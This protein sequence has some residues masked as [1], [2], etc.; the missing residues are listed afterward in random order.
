MAAFARLHIRMSVLQSSA[1]TQF[2]TYRSPWWEFNSILGAL[3]RQSELKSL[4]AWAQR[5]KL[6]GQERW[7][8]SR[9]I[10]KEIRLDRYA[11]RSPRMFFWARV[12]QLVNY[13]IHPH[14]VYSKGYA[15]KYRIAQIA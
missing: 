1:L 15:A 9:L 4:I 6:S 13:L 2:N 12:A 7:Y 14:T 11:R 8:T 5:K 10:D 3:H